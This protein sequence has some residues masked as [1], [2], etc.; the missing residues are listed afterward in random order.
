MLPSRCSAGL[1]I[2]ILKADRLCAGLLQQATAKVFPSA[3]FRHESTICGATA[4][5]AR[6]TADLLLSGIGM[7][8]GDTLDLLG[9]K[10]VDRRGFRHALVVTGRKEHRVLATLRSLPIEGVF[11]PTQDG[12][13]EFEKVVRLVAEGGRYWSPSVIAQL[14][15]QN[16]GANSICRLLSPT[17]QLILAVIGDGSDDNEAAGRLD[18]RPSTIH[19]VRRELHRKLGVQH[20]GELMRVAVQQGFVRFT[21]DGVQRPGFSHLLAACGRQAIAEKS[22]RQ[23][24]DGVVGGFR[25]FAI[26]PV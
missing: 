3:V 24:N 10:E 25:P 1:R 22:P 21:A 20:K 7:M 2:V 19:S 4:F 8:D 13:E 23:S 17:E 9:E 11:D 26:T 6:E 5:L 14:G 18:L 15:A 12:A 16:I